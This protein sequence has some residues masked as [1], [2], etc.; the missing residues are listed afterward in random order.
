MISHKAFSFLGQGL[1]RPECVLSMP[2]GSVHVADWEGGVAI[3]AADGGQRKVLAKGAFVPKPNG[4]AL[5]PNGGWLL[6]HL[7]DGD[8]GV[9]WLKENGDLEPFLLEVDGKPLP[10]TNYVHVDAERRVWITVSTRVH[11]RGDDYRPTAN[12]GFVVLWQN[13]EARIVADGLGYTNEGLVHPQTGVFYVNE[14]FARCTTCYDVAKDG[15]LTNK[16]VV[17]RYGE[18]VFPD[19]LT[20]D[21]HG[22]F[23]ITSIVSNRVIRV[24]VHGDQHLILEDCDQTFIHHVEEAFQAGDMGRPHLDNNTGKVLR[25]IS[26]LAFG[27]GD[28]KTAYLGCLLGDQIVSFTAPIAGLPPSHWQ[29]AERAK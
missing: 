11:P 10:P 2:D 26:S 19:G 17:A 9:Y 14:T 5:H 7:G 13:G 4:I 8:G 3:I 24:D 15:A 16:R 20:F 12:S 22:G 18:G 23:W 27:G 21:D 6:A 1:K 25:N 29:F 28:L